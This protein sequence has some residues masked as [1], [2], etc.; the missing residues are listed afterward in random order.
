MPVARS[1]PTHESP[2]VN[3]APPA[4]KAPDTIPPAPVAILHPIERA[5]EVP[6]L[7]AYSSQADTKY[8]E[9]YTKSTVK[10]QNGILILKL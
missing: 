9:L 8:N 3:T 4:Q 10:H 7:Q 5:A 6:I 1:E 2:K